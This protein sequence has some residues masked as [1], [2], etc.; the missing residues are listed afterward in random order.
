[1]NFD[2]A[3]MAALVR[4]PALECGYVRNSIDVVNKHNINMFS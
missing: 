3:I 1:M 2:L 4:L